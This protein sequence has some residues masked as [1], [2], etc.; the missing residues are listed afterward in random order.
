MTPAMAEWLTK[1][2]DEGAGRPTELTIEGF[3]NGW[4][5]WKGRNSISVVITPAGLAALA[6]YE[7]TT[8]VRR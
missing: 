1:L 4:T 2:R 5:G 3:K 6:E 7:G 8:D